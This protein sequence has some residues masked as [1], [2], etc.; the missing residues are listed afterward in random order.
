MS[1]RQPDMQGENAGLGTEAKNRQHKSHRTPERRQM[2][3][4]HIGKGVVSGIGLQH[5][6]TQQNSQGTNVCHQH[7]EV[8][9]VADFRNSVVGQNQEKR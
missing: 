6:E 2:L 7:V 3:G 1:F 5:P 9:G 8:T 4:P